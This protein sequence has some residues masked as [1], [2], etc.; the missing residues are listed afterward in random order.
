MKK[1]VTNELTSYESFINVS[2]PN[3]DGLTTEQVN[4]IS[5]VNEKGFKV[6][7]LLEADDDYIYG[8]IY[9]ASNLFKDP[10][11]ASFEIIVF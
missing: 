8:V 3:K 4:N 5:I 9:S 11:P 6:G 1:I 2:M 7:H 10:I